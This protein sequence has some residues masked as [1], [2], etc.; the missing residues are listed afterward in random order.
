MTWTVGERECVDTRA[1]GFRRGVAGGLWGNLMD[2]EKET[3]F[4]LAGIWT[5]EL[6]GYGGVRRVG[7]GATSWAT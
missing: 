4:R 2:H 3:G 7:S 6:G 5:P 1:G